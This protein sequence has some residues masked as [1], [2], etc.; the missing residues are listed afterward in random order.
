MG[1]SMEVLSILE[2]YGK[3]KIEILNAY[4]LDNNKSAKLE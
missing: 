2:E 1:A 4:G 3:W